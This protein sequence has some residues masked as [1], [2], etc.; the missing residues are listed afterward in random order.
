MRIPHK[1]VTVSLPD[2]LVAK[3]DRSSRRLGLTRSGLAA[4]WLR[5]GSREQDKADLERDIE[6]YYAEQGPARAEDA[7]ISRAAARLARRLRVDEKT[8]RPPRRKHR[9]S[10]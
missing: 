9:S 6:A 4:Q 10:P 1:R 5:R 2:E 8:T 3:L 7:S